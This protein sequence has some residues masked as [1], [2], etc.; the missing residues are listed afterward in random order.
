VSYLEDNLRALEARFPS[1]AS[2]LRGQGP[3]QGLELRPSKAGPPTAL[4]DGRQLH[5]A[6]D[7]RA[8]ARKLVSALG[9]REACLFQG[10][11]LGYLPE[12]LLA[13][14]PDAMAIVVEPDP[15]LFRAALEARPLQALLS[16]QRLS[17][18]LGGG[19][20][21]LLYALEELGPAD[22]AILPL[23]AETARDPGFFDA[24]AKA[25]ERY[26]E[27]TRVNQATLARFGGL[28]VRNLVRNWDRS[29]RAPGISALTGRLTGIPA[30]IVAA[31]PSLDGLRPR[32]PELA[33]RMAIIAVDTSAALVQASG[34]SPDF[35][36]LVDPQYWNAR[37]ID[38][39][40]PG[41]SI[42]IAES[43]AYPSALRRPWRAVFF[44]ASI[45]P[46]GRYM[47]ASL[48][49]RGRLGAGGS[50]ATSAW[51][52][53]RISGA[54]PLYFAG[55]DLGYPGRATHVSGSLFE[56]RAL[57]S[58][59]RLHP[60]ETSAHAALHALQPYTA[61][62]NRGQSIL[63]DKRMALYAWWFES[64]LARH[65]ECSTFSLSPGGLAIPG[66]PLAA[67]DDLLNLPERRAEID[68]ALAGIAALPGPDPSLAASSR[69]NLIRLLEEMA[70]AA[71]EAL[72]AARSARAAL[73]LG[74]D[75]T[76]PLRRLEACD[77]A[78]LANPAKD[79]VS[80]MYSLAE[81]P[82]P[83][84]PLEASLALYGRIKEAVDYH[85]DR[86][87]S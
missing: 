12:E 27:K 81:A 77:A 20:A 26:L 65:P 14:D 46:L 9:R 36:V 13:A 63:T 57:Q 22:V 85:L 18:V 60:A 38:A 16:D 6:Y 86:L 21:S 43:A 70:A 53:A 74:R 7:P 68:A 64:R 59:D 71:E 47:E 82:L 75:A 48:P 41:P 52:F 2:S 73:S 33:R 87:R 79:I 30:L 54:G 66:M 15:T 44:C 50:V 62:D 25:L 76:E 58:A 34:A 17:L 8:E 83:Q 55:L 84:D 10:F 37:H 69:R 45:F 28:W 24:C 61:P 4:L 78:L 29:L 42:L 40:D 67:V 72:A 35:T 19:P 31:G 49:G 39:L 11:G 51:D 3:C 32:L 80:F 5:S 23:G 56:R 1:L